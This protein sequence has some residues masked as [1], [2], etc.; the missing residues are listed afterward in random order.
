MSTLCPSNPAVTE[1]QAGG[2]AAS[3]SHSMRDQTSHMKEKYQSRYSQRRLSTK[4]SSPAPAVGSR[5]GSRNNSLPGDEVEVTRQ[6]LTTNK[7]VRTLSGV[8]P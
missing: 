2:S 3:R 6:F 8:A 5:S 1:L 7:K 4:N